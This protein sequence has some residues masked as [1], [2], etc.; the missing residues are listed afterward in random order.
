MKIPSVVVIPTLR[1]VRLKMWEIIRAVV[2]FPFEPVTATIGIRDGDPGGNSRSRTCLATSCGSPSV[3]LVCIR[4]PGAAFTST[5]APPLSRTGWAMSGARKSI[6]ATS[7]PTTWAASSAT[8]TF[9]SCAS[10]V[11]SMEM[12]PVDMLPVAAS[13]TVSPSGG[14]SSMSKPCLRTSPSPCRRP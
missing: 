14:T 7:R 12:P 1:P 6:P 4:N 9:S 13:I 5:M 8:S 2:V 10:Q 3:G 11:R